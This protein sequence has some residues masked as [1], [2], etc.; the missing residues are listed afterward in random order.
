MYVDIHFILAVL[1]IFIIAPI[2]FAIAFFRNDM[3]IW[4]FQAILGLGLVLLAYQGYKLFIRLVQKSS[5]AWVNAIHV[6]L[7]APLLLYI[8]YNQ[9][10]TP[11][12]AY[13]L[14]AMAGFAVLGYHLYSLVQQINTV[15]PPS[16]P[17]A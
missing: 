2:F 5:Y 15:T 1:H 12:A 7:I 6:F 16:K 8:G 13:E 4:A 11:R 14:T 10:K 9:Q 17:S 3:P